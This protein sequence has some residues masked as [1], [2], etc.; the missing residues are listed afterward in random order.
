[1]NKVSDKCVN[2]NRHELHTCVEWQAGAGG[3]RPPTPSQPLACLQ[4]QL[5]HPVLTIIHNG[6]STVIVDINLLLS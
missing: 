5:L 3:R 1:M 6:G 2:E 4:V